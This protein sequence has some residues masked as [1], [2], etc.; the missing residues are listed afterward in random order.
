MGFLKLSKEFLLPSLALKTLPLGS[1]NGSAGWRF[2]W[3]LSFELVLLCIS[4]TWSWDRTHGTL[5][6][7]HWVPLPC[8][9]GPEWLISR[10]V[11]CSH[12]NSG[13][14][15]WFQRTCWTPEGKCLVYKAKHASHFRKKCAGGWEFRRLAG[16]CSL[17]C[18]Q[19]ALC[20][21]ANR[22]GCLLTLFF[23]E[24][25]VFSC[26]GSQTGGRKSQKL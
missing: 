12:G 10:W 3:K 4:W 1:D 19:G 16:E 20:G 24:S 26:L 14:G 7:A 8:I 17:S 2:S 18:W 6:N 15:P 23:Q 11:G 21:L 25:T 5:R 22:I 13:Q 9:L